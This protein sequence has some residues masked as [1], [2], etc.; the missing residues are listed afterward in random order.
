LPRKNFL[1]KE[2]LVD[3]YIIRDLNIRGC[4]KVLGVHVDTVRKY[5]V[6]YGITIKKKPQL[7]DDCGRFIVK[8]QV[9]PPVPRGEEHHLYINGVGIY[10]RVAA[11]YHPKRCF[12][13]HSTKKLEVHH[14][15]RNRENNQWWNLRFVCQTCHIKIEH[16]DKLFRRDEKGR[17]I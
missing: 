17:F 10:R 8:G 6:R 2:D 4:A 16:T 5:L 15:D 13:C 3:L 7:R 11:S 1:K 9:L 12:H 14:I